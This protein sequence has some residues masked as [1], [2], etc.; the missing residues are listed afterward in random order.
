MRVCGG[1]ALGS[2]GATGLIRGSSCEWNVATAMFDMHGMVHSMLY[3]MLVDLSSAL[4]AE[5]MSYYYISVIITYQLSLHISHHYISV[6]ITYQ[7]L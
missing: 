2:A 6:I 7:L 5:H 3:G 4:R 1:E